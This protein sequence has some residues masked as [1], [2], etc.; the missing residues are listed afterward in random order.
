MNQILALHETI[1]VLEDALSV[2]RSFELVQKLR[3]TKREFHAMRDKRLKRFSL[4]RLG[5]LSAEHPE[6]LAIIH[7]I[8]LRSLLQ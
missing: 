7:E 1:L 8:Q 4:E 2:F 6:R 3:E 5:K